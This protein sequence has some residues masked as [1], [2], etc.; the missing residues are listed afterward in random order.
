MGCLFGV[1]GSL[2]IALNSTCS[3]GSKQHETTLNSTVLL[4]T[5]TNEFGKKE[6]NWLRSNLSVNPPV[7]ATVFY[8]SKVA[9]V[10]VLLNCLCDPQNTN[11]QRT[12]T[13]NVA[14][15]IQRNLPEKWTSL[16]TRLLRGMP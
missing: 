3:L 14:N 6:T 9:N 1:K 4:L 8:T 12:C 16:L 11:A 13:C 2:T 10:M 15:N 7:T 5:A